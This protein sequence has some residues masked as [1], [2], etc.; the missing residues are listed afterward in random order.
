MVAVE[1]VALAITLV[2][3]R[4][5]IKIEN[6]LALAVARVVASAVALTVA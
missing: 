2:V 5:K 3:A 6:W 4:K 1:A